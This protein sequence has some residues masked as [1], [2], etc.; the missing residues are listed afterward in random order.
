MNDKRNNEIDEQMLMNYLEGKLSP[1]E[2]HEV[3]SAMLES[4]FLD[5]AVDGLSNITNKQRAAVILD[6]LN[7]DIT[8]KTTSKKD[9]IKYNYLIPN[10]QTLIITATITILL[11]AIIGFVIIK[12][13]HNS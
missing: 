10:M 12:M 4:P 2:Q 1:E 6:E 11:M 13:F 3:E 5:D 9:K 7:K 8:Q